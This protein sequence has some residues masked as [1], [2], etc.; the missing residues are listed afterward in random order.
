MTNHGQPAH[1][2]PVVHRSALHL[3]VR[4]TSHTDAPQPGPPAVIEQPR[5][6]RNQ[7]LVRKVKGTS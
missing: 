2:L 7:R 1:R 4:L 6:R 3:P 5:R